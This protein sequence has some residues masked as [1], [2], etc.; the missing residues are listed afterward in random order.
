[1]P[2]FTVTHKHYFPP[3]TAVNVIQES[4]NF[5]REIVHL[6]TYGMMFIFGTL[7]IKKKNKKVQGKVQVL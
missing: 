3:Q 2:T 5:D 4:A 7:Q 1:M 6:F